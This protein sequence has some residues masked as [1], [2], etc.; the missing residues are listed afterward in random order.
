MGLRYRK[1][2]KL[3][4]GF[5]VNLSKFVI[6]YSWGVK[7]FRVGKTARGTT[8]T[9]MSVPGTGISRV[10]ETR[11]PVRGASAEQL[12]EEYADLYPKP[13]GTWKLVLAVCSWV[14]A[15]VAF[16]MPLIGSE[17]GSTMFLAA[18]FYLSLGGAFFLGW[19]LPRKKW[20]EEV[21]PRAYRLWLIL[22]KRENA[23]AEE[24]AR[25]PDR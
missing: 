17:Y 8:R 15:L 20:E 4:G 22:Q 13:R 2:S 5:L 18:L 11:A 25:D 10:S 9:T 21:L 23:E 1:S 24:R 3:P 6:G 7:G 19:Y 14:T 12:P 16:I